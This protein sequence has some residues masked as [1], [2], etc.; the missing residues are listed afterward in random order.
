MPIVL[1]LLLFIG[2]FSWTILFFLS[3]GASLQRL[4]DASWGLG[5]GGS[6]LANMVKFSPHYL[7]GRI[8]LLGL[9]FPPIWFMFPLI[10]SGGIRKNVFNGFLVISSICGLLFFFLWSSSIGLYMDWNLFALPLFPAILLFANNFTRQDFPLKK[11]I[12]CII[13]S[14]AYYM[15]YSWIISN[16]ILSS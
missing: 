13:F 14:V 1:S 2:F 4:I 8:N 16:H 10:I 12:V 7:W 5:R 11:Q 9:V 6:V 3:R 15:T